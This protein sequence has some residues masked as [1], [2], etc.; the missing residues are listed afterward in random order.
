MLNTGHTGVGPPIQH[1]WRPSKR[2][3]CEHRGVYKQRMFS[4]DEGKDQS[5]VQ[6]ERQ[7]RWPAKPQERGARAELPTPRPRRRTSRAGCVSHLPCGPVRAAPVN[8]HG[9]TLVPP[10]SHTAAL[11]PRQRG[12]RQLQRRPRAPKARR[13]D[14]RRHGESLLTPHSPGRRVSARPAGSCSAVPTAA[15]AQRP[16]PPPQPAPSPRRARR[17]PGKGK[18]ESNLGSRAR[19]PLWLSSNEVL[20]SISFWH[21]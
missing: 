12:A 8:W 17:C 9:A 3:Q 21:P 18:Q 1:D 10:R 19:A 5:D 14:R 16:A 20:V 11:T 13:A 7:R 4:V 6:T 15:H 2:G